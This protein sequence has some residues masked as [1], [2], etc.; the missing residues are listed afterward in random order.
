MTLLT[1]HEVVKRHCSAGEQICAVDH[2]NLTLQREQM[3]CIHG[4]SGSGKTTL[5]LL[6]AALLQ[7]DSG[8]I[9]LEGRPLAQLDERARARL[10]RRQLGLITQSTRL[11]PRVSAL[12]NATVKLLLD[13][14]PPR[15]ARARALPLLARLGLA[16]RLHHPPEQL[17]SGERQRVAIARALISGPALLLADE[18]TAHLDSASSIATVQL[19]RKLACEQGAGVLLVT[20]DTSAAALA[21]RSFE[22][23]DGRLRRAEPADGLGG[24]AADRAVGCAADGVA[25]G[26]AGGVADGAAHWQRR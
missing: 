14:V 13:G 8:E 25:G 18:P 19:L 21:D 11:M 20:H 26:G 15:R 16:D 4:P 22:M 23:R 1:V 2:V 9:C 24:D 3:L 6:I 17:S 10:L 7:P 5:L 12:E